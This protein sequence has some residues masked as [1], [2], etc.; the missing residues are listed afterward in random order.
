MMDYSEHNE[1]GI[2]TEGGENLE[3][4]MVP[5]FV[6][7]GESAKNGPASGGEPAESGFVSGG[8]AAVEPTESGS[9]PG[10]ELAESGFV[11]GG[12]T[13]MEPA[14]NDPVSGG[15]IPTGE[16]SGGRNSG[17]SILEVRD[18]H[19]SFGKKEVVKGISFSMK[20][21]E[22]MGL[23][24]PNGAGKTTSFYMI[25]GFYKPTSGNVLVNGNSITGLPMYKRA[26][27]GLAYL[28][29]EPSIFRKLSVEK[30]ILAVLESRKELTPAER[31]NKMDELIER[32]SISHIR[33]QPAYTLSGGER[34]RTEIAR[35]LAGDPYF[36]LLD[37]PFAG[38][39]PKAVHEIKQIIRRLADSGIGILL[40]DHNVRDTLEITTRAH[41]ISE[42]EILV[43]GTKE[44]LLN[45]EKARE[46][47]FG[48][49]FD[50][51]RE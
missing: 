27:L 22:I 50:K 28:P 29:Q 14:K 2:N 36:L 20:N 12:A 40:T 25:V 49:D 44:E 43:S 21:G 16:D 11:S 38:I 32:F 5:G 33:K 8:A 17:K 39:D 34:R 37:E 35:A 41:I 3:K 48:R 18:I 26:R 47:Y 24:G 13:A 30:N 51:E 7:G 23:L 19:K 9:A 1:G 4:A 6:P 46:I 42:G 15:E 45:N 10:G 31:K